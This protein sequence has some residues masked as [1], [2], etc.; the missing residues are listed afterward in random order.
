MTKVC[1]KYNI[2]RFFLKDHVIGRS[3]GR[4]IGHKSI[5]SKDEEIKL[6]EYIDLFVKWGYLMILT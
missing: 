6:Y 1:K 2:S 3:K 4:K 5:L